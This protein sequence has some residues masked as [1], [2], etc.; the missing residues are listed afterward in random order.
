[1]CSVQLRSGGLKDALRVYDNIE[2]R[3]TLF[4]SCGF[5]VCFRYKFWNILQ[6]FMAISLRIQE[7][8]KFAQTPSFTQLRIGE[9][10]IESFAQRPSVLHIFAAIT[11]ACDKRCVHTVHLQ[12]STYFHFSILL[13]GVRRISIASGWH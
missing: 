12:K 8:H 13:F 7:L 2:F 1:M 11:S 9:N 3:M 10:V 5:R 4:F 6:S